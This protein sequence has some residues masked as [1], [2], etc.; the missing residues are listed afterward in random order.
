MKI[1]SVVYLTTTENI[2][3]EKY[4][5]NDLKIAKIYCFLY[6]NLD[7]NTFINQSDGKDLFYSNFCKYINLL[8]QNNLQPADRLFFSQLNHVQSKSKL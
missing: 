4:S 1:W 2:L 5:H 6:E 8:I 3:F 7:K